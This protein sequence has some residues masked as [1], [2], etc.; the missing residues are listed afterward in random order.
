MPASGD[1]GPS[2]QIAAGSWPSGAGAARKRAHTRSAAAGS[3]SQR[4][5]HSATATS[6]S[7][8]Q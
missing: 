2:G 7:G 4:A 3:G 6:W 1:P 8:L 5:W